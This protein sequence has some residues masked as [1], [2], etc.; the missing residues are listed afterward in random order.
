MY[1]YHSLVEKREPGKTYHVCDVRW[2]NFHIW[3]NSKLAK[4]KARDTE[5]LNSLISTL[6]SA[7]NQQVKTLQPLHYKLKTAIC[8]VTRSCPWPGGTDLDEGTRIELLCKSQFSIHNKGTE[9]APLAD[10]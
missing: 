2:N 3:H 5:S 6:Q 10:S 4:I 8:M 9:G 7:M 1:P